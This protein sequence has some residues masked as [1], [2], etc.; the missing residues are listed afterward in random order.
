MVSVW[1]QLLNCCYW[2]ISELTRVLCET[3]T[4]VHVHVHVR[5]PLLLIQLSFC[6][7]LGLSIYGCR[8]KAEKGS[9][10]ALLWQSFILKHEPFDMACTLD[11]N[12][13][14]STHLLN[15]LLSSS[16]LDITSTSQLCVIL[17]IPILKVV[18]L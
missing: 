3:H 1:I 16:W 4:C 7:P 17:E 6:I 14:T 9:C 15:I 12:L 11:S 18:R 10:S 5:S 13:Y 8:R 2:L